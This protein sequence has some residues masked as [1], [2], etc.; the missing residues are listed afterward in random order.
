MIMADTFAA[1]V[2]WG[3]DSVGTATSM[4]LFLVMLSYTFEIYFNFSGFCDMVTGISMM[5]NISLPINFDSPYKSLSI[6]EFWKRW[7]ISLTSF[8]TKY[9]YIPLGG[10]RKRELLNILIFWL[11]SSWAVLGMEQIGHLSYEDCFM[12]CWI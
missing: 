11:F 5:M 1:A 7:H 4:D 12:D 2:N 6:R 3:F 9:I 8:F 10:N